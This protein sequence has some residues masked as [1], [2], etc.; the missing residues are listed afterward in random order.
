MREY[1]K[2]VEAL[3]VKPDERLVALKPKPKLMSDRLSNSRTNTQARAVESGKN[4]GF[5][6]EF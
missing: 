6:R 3:G 4:K 5:E 1:F 2:G